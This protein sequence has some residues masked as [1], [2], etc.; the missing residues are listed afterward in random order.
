MLSIDRTVASD[1][2]FRYRALARMLSGGRRGPEVGKIYGSW[3]ELLFSQWGKFVKGP[4]LVLK[5]EPECRDQ[6]YSNLRAI[7]FGVIMQESV[8]RTS[9]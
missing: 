5:S 3:P 6:R 8:L 7:P 2:L 9:S 1:K 4:V